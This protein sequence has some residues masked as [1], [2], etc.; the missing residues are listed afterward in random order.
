MRSARYRLGRAMAAWREAGEYSRKKRRFESW[1]ADLRKHPPDCLVGS[2]FASYG[3][4]RAHIRAI[5]KYSALNV[6]L[7]PS[8]EAL[9][10]LDPHDFKTS[11]REAFLDYDGAGISVAHSHVFPWFIEWCMR[12][13]G[14]GM[15]WVHTYHAP[16]LPEY[17]RGPL[18]PW[19]NEI[20]EYL[21]RHARH[22]DVRIS[23]ARWEQAWLREVHDIETAYLPNG[24]DVPACDLGDAARFSSRTGRRDFVLFVGRNDPV[25]NPAD[26]VRLAARMPDREFV[27]MGGGLSAEALRSDWGIEVPENLTLYGD[28]SPPDVQDAMAACGAVVMTSRREGLPTVV[29][30]AMAHS[31]PVVVP[32]EPGCVEAIDGGRCGWIYSPDAMDDLVEKTRLALNGQDTA[33]R[34]RER[35][36]SEYD[37]RV[38]A[39]RLDMIYRGESP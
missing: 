26:F 37:W 4:M 34:G 32:D 36:L 38:V 23:V 13:R 15:R 28:A 11:F 16:Y 35:V 25:K 3:G 1:I 27:M 12:H 30:E 19:Q 9:E 5:Q 21:I 6:A 20:N 39:P 24:V 17:A 2:N 22:A 33:A 14:P 18:L 8:D 7:A 29:L 31:R 10:G